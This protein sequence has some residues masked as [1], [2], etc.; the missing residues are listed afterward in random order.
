MLPA[1][2]MP[3]GKDDV[4][5]LVKNSTLVVLDS[6]GILSNDYDVTETQFSLLYLI[7]QSMDL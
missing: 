7:L 1:N 4:Y 5:G 2:D 3:I 6:L